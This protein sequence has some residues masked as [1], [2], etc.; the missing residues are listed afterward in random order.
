M[1][2]AVKDTRCV[3]VMIKEYGHYLLLHLHGFPT[4]GAVDN[5]VE[6][7]V[8]GAGIAFHNRGPAIHDCLYLFPFL[9]CHNRLMTTL[10]D[11]PV[12]TGNDVIYFDQEGIILTNRFR[13]YSLRTNVDHDISNAFQ[14]G[15]SI[16][17]SKTASS[18]PASITKTARAWNRTTPRPSTPRC[19]TCSI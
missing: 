4:G 8:E 13:R 10:N 7:I 17:L 14:A 3:A 2:G 5:A 12:L 9:R 19:P 15:V 1:I 16:A 18:A 6:Q 11:F